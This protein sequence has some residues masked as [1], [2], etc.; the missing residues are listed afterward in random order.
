MN[1]IKT[2]FNFDTLNSEKNYLSIRQL[3]VDKSLHHK[4]RLCCFLNNCFLG[5]NC[6]IIKILNRH[7]LLHLSYLK[8]I[9]CISFYHIGIQGIFFN[10]NK[11][12]LVNSI[13]ENF[14]S[15]SRDS[16]YII[17]HVWS[18]MEKMALSLFINAYYQS[19]KVVWIYLINC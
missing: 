6:F 3:V 16:G 12:I 1:L 18:R 13:P 14:F 5:S 17:K 8:P 15:S 9:N 10:S 4:Q 11:Y 19:S 7:Q 2:K